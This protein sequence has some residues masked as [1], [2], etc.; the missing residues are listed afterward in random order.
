M[1]RKYQYAIINEFIE[2]KGQ[3]PISIP[4]ILH[5]RWFNVNKCESLPPSL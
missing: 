2:L 1:I 5:D 4:Q 3:D